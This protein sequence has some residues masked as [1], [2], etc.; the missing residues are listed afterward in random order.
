[1][2]GIRITLFWTSPYKKFFPILISVARF[3]K[4]EPDSTQE[5]RSR[6]AAAFG[7]KT[8]YWHDFKL[9]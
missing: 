3:L 7:R 8:R 9:T 2:S 6:W 1:V 5:R 4:C